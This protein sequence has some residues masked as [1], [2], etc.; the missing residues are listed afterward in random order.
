[1]KKNYDDYSV[2]EDA[3]SY[4]SEYYQEDNYDYNYNNK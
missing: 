3:S 2:S 1:M 4:N